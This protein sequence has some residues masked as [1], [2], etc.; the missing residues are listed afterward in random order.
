MKAIELGRV[1]EE[2]ATA[3]LIWRGYG[4]CE[5]NYRYRQGEIDIIAQ[6]EKVL[7]FVEVKTRRCKKYGLPCEA[8]SIR[9]QHTIK[10]MALR[11]L[12]QSKQSHI[13]F[14]FD[15][16]EVYAG[17]DD[18]YTVNHLIDCFR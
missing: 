12:Q 16:I 7:I 3:Y 18:L 2:I 11:Y 17:D 1:G 10:S 9:K 5:R 6:K 14:R 15:V 13:S 8:V 4:I